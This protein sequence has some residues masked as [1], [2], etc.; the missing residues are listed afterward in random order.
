MLAP[1]DSTDSKRKQLSPEPSLKF[2]SSFRFIASMAALLLALLIA[3]VPAARG[4]LTITTAAIGGIVEDSSG[5][6]IP[7]AAVQI[8]STERGIVR[9][10]TTNQAGRYTFSQLPPSP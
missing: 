6:V 3:V 5:A 9:K 2:D 1:S 10:T 4:Q 7:N 8:A